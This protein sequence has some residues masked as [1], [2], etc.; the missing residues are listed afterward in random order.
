ME[1]CLWVLLL[2]FQIYCAISNKV[3]MSE[4]VLVHLHIQLCASI[5]VSDCTFNRVQHI[6]Q[7]KVF[8][9]KMRSYSNHSNQIICLHSIQHIMFPTS[10]DS[11]PICAHRWADPRQLPVTAD[12]RG[13]S[14]EKST[15]GARRTLQT[16]RL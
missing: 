7:K 12:S 9:L 16:T 1:F 2:H 3:Q 14:E 5:N 6:R 11:R 4:L 8:F 13:G 15:G 10:I